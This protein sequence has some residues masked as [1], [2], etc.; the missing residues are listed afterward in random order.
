MVQILDSGESPGTNVLSTQT[1]SGV[2]DEL[3]WRSVALATPPFVPKETSFAIALSSPGFCVIFGGPFQ[4]DP[5]PRGNA[6]TRGRPIQPGIWALAG[7]DLGFR[8]Y[9]ERMCKV[10]SLLG[11]FQQAAQTLIG[12]NGCDLGRI[13]RVFSMTVPAGQIVSQGKAE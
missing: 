9:V 12:T 13:T 7:L 3:E 10:P 1:I 4:G 2:S 6:G 5:Y 8:T 11:L